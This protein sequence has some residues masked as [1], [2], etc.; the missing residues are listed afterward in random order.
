MYVGMFVCMPIG[1]RPMGSCPQH[2]VP[3]KKE[4][5]YRGGCQNCSPFSG[6]H[7][8]GDIDID[9]DMVRYRFIVWVLVEIMVP[10]GSLV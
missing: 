9:V 1:C 10:F 3:G 4:I 7:S 6:V 5:W 2:K 8:K